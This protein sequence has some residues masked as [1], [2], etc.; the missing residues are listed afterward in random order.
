MQRTVKRKI[1]GFL[2]EPDIQIV[3]SAVSD[4]HQIISSASILLRAYILHKFERDEACPEVNED[5]IRYCCFVVQGQANLEFR[6]TK[7][8]SV[9]ARAQLQALYRDLQGVYRDLYNYFPAPPIVQSNFSISHIL[10]YSI[11]NLET[12]Y[13]T[14][15]TT[16]FLKYL[17]R[18][19]LCDQLSTFERPPSKQYLKIVKKYS[20][21]VS[22]AM[23]YG[24]GEDSECEQEDI[25]AYSFLLP[26]RFYP[27]MPHCYNIEAKPWKY[28]NSMVL[29]RTCLEQE[30]A[31]LE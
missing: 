8:A 2:R 24:V 20:W 29:I 22:N 17:K 31:T 15:I 21:T 23:F 11:S 27:N 13:K 3:R 1:R 30:H 14:N 6:A 9:A 26:D 12:A 7:V 28:L 25:E 16:H 10:A 4:V 5:L 18:Y 19:I